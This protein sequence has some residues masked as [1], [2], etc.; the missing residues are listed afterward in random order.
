MT[1]PSLGEEVVHQQCRLARRRRAFE[2]SRG[3]ADDDV[4]PLEPRQHLAQCERPGHCVELVAGLDEPWGGG[5]VQIGTQCDDQYVTFKDARLG[6]DAFGGRIDRGDGGLDESEPWLD[7]SV[8]GVEDRRRQDSS[9]H[10]VKFRK[11]ED[12]PLALVDQIDIKF[13][14]ELL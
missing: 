12:E 6:L 9:E 11:P 14:T 8:V 13:L 7:Q 3:H 5:R 2:R 1:D 4:S 10:H